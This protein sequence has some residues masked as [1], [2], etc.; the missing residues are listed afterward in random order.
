VRFFEDSFFYLQTQTTDRSYH[1]DNFLSLPV[2]VIRAAVK[3]FSD[4]ARKKANSESFTVAQIASMAHS[5]F[6]QGKGGYTYEDFL[7]F[8]IGRESNRKVLS[9]Q[10]A[11]IF[12]AL[13]DEGKLPMK[14]LS[15]SAKHLETIKGYGF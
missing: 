1:H 3:Q 6:S 13:L 15:A 7:P 4:L 11:K 5:Y 12:V 14:L 2:R 8:K 9:R 10:T